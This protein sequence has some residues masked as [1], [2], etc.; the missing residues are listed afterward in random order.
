MFSNKPIRHSKENQRRK[1][2][3]KIE[4]KHQIESNK[5]GN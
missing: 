2:M 4:Y 5:H 1:R 3:K